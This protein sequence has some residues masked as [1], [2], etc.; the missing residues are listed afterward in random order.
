MEKSSI[1]ESL[2]S[3]SDIVLIGTVHLDSV[4]KNS[5]KEAMMHVRGR[6][7]TVEISRFSVCYRAA[8]E[9]R[10]L[11]QLRN[12]KKNLTEGR[13]GHSRLKLLERQLM[14]PFEW[15]AAREL[16]EAEGIPYIPIDSSD[17][18]RADLPLWSRELISAENL[19]IVTRKPDFGL[20]DHFNTCHAQARSILTDESICES[21]Y[22][23]LT[24]LNDPYW[25]R[26]EKILAKRVRR[27]AGLR[28][29]MLH[30]GGWMHLVKG[31]PWKTMTDLLSDLE[32]RRI[33]ITRTGEGAYGH[34]LLP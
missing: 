2:S 26:R 11:S 34:L 27:I 9:A 24:W 13:Q 15:Q 18:A 19:D 20:N 14:T 30:I 12:S 29:P 33:F 3:S 4:G 22:H 16:G 7:I 6:V 21:D 25:S 5:L 32:P 17:T 31:L 23:T 10:W 1:F 28:V 8:H